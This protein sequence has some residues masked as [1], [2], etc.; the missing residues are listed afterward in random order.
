MSEKSCNTFQIGLALAGYQDH[1]DPKLGTIFE[2]SSVGT[3][4]DLSLVT[5][6]DEV[7][8]LKDAMQVKTWFVSNS[9]F[10]IS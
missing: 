4:Q 2:H 7:S 3:A 6:D 10:T 1:I 8:R 9:G 5:Y